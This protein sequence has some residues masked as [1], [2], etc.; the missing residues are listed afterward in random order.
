MHTTKQSHTIS[1]TTCILCNQSTHY[2]N[3]LTSKYLLVHLTH[4][5]T[6]WTAAHLFV[7][8]QKSPGKATGE[9][10]VKKYWIWRLSGG[11]S[12]HWP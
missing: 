6:N 8:F 10:W 4:N 1:I 5:L 9:S 3:V 12:K 2:V 7:V 11:D